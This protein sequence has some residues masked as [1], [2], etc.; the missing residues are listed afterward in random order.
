[1]F[2]FPTAI[3]LDG[4]NVKGYTVWSFLDNLE[5]MEGFAEKF[6]IYA[7]DFNHPNRTRTAKASAVFYR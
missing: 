4:C 1:M 6:G 2:L 7:V 3:T 5:W